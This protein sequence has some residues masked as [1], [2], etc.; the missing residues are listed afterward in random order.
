MKFAELL[1]I[2]GDDPLFDAS[3]LRVG[4]ANPRD[5]AT[6]LSRWVHSGRIVQLRRGLYA[7][8]TPYARTRPAQFLIANRL[9]EPSYV[10]EEAALSFHGLI[11]DVVQTVTSVTSG[12]GGVRRTPYGAFDYRHI[13]PSLLWGFEET[14]VDRY[15]QVALVA[16]PE[17]ALLD[18]VYLR[19][20]SDS[21][22]FVAELRLQNTDRVDLL[23]L[24][25]MACRFDVPRVMRAAQVIAEAVETEREGWVEL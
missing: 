17:K 19:K 6:Q 2:V 10:S 25:A 8:A 18:L 11:P 23:Q 20:G 13:K 21:R 22:A 3:L 14:P 9:V 12:K 7:L 5:V 15:G 1:E 16:V 4:E 24:E